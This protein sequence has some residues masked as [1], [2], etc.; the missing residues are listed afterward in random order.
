MSARMR[1]L[2]L[3]CA[4]TLALGCEPAKA[5]NKVDVSA[6]AKPAEAPEAQTRVYSELELRG[7]DQAVLNAQAVVWRSQ[8]GAFSRA[9]AAASNQLM[10]Q[11]RERLDERKPPSDAQ[12][13]SFLF[14]ANNHGER[15]DC[16]CKA[17]PLGGL[18]RRATLIKLAREG[19]AQEQQYWNTIGPRTDSIFVVDAGES[20]FK[21][22]YFDVSKQGVPKQ[23]LE[24]AQGVVEGMN[25][26]P[27]DVFN[28]GE[29]ELALGW[30]ALDVLRKKA[31][32]PMISA[33]LRDEAGKPLL[34]PSLVVERGGRKVAF[35]G[36]M[37][38]HSRVPDFLKARKLS[39]E[40]PVEAYA[41]ALE[42]VP[43][44]VDAVV[45]LS[46]E[47]VVDTQK[48]VERL[49]AKALRVDLAL[50]SG[51][52]QMTETPKW[53]QGVPV[54][55]PMSQGKYFARVDL[56]Q[57]GPK[58]WSFGN[59]YPDAVADLSAYR[60][61]WESYMHGRLAIIQDTEALGTIEL[62][63]LKATKQA[64]SAP[65]A[66]PAPGPAKAPQ[67]QEQLRA[68]LDQRLKQQRKRQDLYLKT[69]GDEVRAL[70]RALLAP[71]PTG[72]DWVDVRVVEV[73]ITIPQEPK[74]RKVLDRYK[75]KTWYGQD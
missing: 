10:Q 59:N 26:T 64:Q 51:S 29:R 42:R 50:V 57:A 61:A 32:F 1:M 49:K 4:L 53:A 7:N 22:A 55:E 31:K 16:G 28:V 8:L 19:G 39:V 60:Q 41:K 9:M 30:G 75:G 12:V 20:L 58:S 65:S 43:Q 6:S 17:K 44:D 73:K 35:I 3:L 11:Q 21:D 70:E 40:E 2:S 36:L 27:P 66:S 72:E 23:M 15:E 18:D 52:N 54:I 45:L 34:E 25:V 46:N 13:L 33:N 24:L 5:P 56:Y 69:W 74:T 38:A 48:L 62:E 68:R 37:R 71:P 14:S 63:K 47:G 67:D